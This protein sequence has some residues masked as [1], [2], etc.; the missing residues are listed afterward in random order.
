METKRASIKIKELNIEM[1]M[2]IFDDKQEEG[3]YNEEEKVW[4]L[5]FMS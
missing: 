1:Y 5:T 2:P 4:I 3:A